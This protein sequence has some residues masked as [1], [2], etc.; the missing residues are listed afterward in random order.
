MP[1]IRNLDADQGEEAE[2]FPTLSAVVASGR[3]EGSVKRESDSGTFLRAIELGSPSG[4]QQPVKVF[5]QLSGG[6]PSTPQFTGNAI[7]LGAILFFTTD[8]GIANRKYISLVLGNL[9]LSVS[10]YTFHDNRPEVKLTGLLRK[11]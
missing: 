8:D 10:T 3:Y 5:E 2:I 1:A 9:M 4:T 7:A 11:K 6:L